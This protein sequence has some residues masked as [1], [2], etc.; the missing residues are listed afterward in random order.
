MVAKDLIKTLGGPSK[1]GRLLGV[2]PQAISLWA[3]KS[4]VPVERVPAL[5]RLA[6]SQGLEVRPEDFRAD[7]DWAALR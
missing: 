6:K 4:R 1:L 5:I 3:S 7:V 2:K